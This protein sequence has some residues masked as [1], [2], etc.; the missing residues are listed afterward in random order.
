MY[1]AETRSGT[2]NFRGNKKLWDRFVRK[3][4]KEEKK[5]FDVLRPAIDDF[6]KQK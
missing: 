3:C 2:L 6:L 5:I 1:V 4:R